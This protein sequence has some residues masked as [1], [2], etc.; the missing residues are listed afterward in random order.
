TMFIVGV[1]ASALCALTPLTISASFELFVAIRFLSGFI[2]A[3]IYP[4]V[5]TIVEE[6]APMD[7]KG[8]F[9]AVLSSFVELDQLVTPPI[10][11][12]IAEKINWPL[13]F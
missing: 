13:M 4:V 12:L 1:A 10:G 3:P 8:I 9:V 2:T 7:E 6:W 5:G 11:S